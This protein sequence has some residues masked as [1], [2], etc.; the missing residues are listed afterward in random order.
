METIF[1]APERETGT[2][3]LLLL[4]VCDELHHSCLSSATIII[5]TKKNPFVEEVGGNC[6]ES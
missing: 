1:E 5:I 2:F 4:L 3:L 6:A